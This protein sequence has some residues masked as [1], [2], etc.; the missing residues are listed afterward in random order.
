MKKE[1]SEI[2][3][4]WE[5]E[6]GEIVEFG[7][8]FMRCYDKAGKLQLGK[9]YFDSKTGEKKYLIKFVLDRKELLDSKEGLSYLQETLDEWEKDYEN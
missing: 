9:A 2:N 1:K 3:K 5:L 6:E 7:H 4:Y 8:S